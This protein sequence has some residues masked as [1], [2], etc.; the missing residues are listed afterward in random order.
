MSPLSDVQRTVLGT[1]KY[2][3]QTDPQ[4][5]KD[6]FFLVGEE[7]TEKNPKAS[8]LVREVFVP[9]ALSTQD[10]TYEG[11]FLY[12]GLQTLKYRYR[13][14]NSTSDE[15]TQ[16]G[17]EMPYRNMQ[18]LLYASGSPLIIT[19]PNFHGVDDRIF[20][21]NYTRYGADGGGVKLYRRLDGYSGESK[22]LSSPE[23]INTETNEPFVEN[24]ILKVD[25]A[26]IT[27]SGVRG[28]VAVQ[29]NT[30]TF[31]CNP[32]IDPVCRLKLAPVG[33]G[34]EMCYP[35]TLMGMSFQFPCSAMNVFTPMV[36]GERVLPVLWTS[37]LVEVPE[38]RLKLFV[39]SVWVL[40]A[41]CIGIIVFGILFV[42]V[43]GVWIYYTCSQYGAKEKTASTYG[44]DKKSL[45]AATAQNET[46]DN[47]AMEEENL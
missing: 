28:Q 12:F 2:I 35:T 32:S 42:I 11:N 10:M 14:K 3:G 9:L 23:E 6:S 7:L 1:Q 18:N 13:A 24:F 45:W 26:A 17:G 41:L 36:R 20:N 31:N 39:Y 15:R 30:F 38:E 47:A 21:Q 16:R 46:P 4:P 25:N 19:L 8:N 40:Y 5:M 44:V 29:V 27:G 33:A 34:P 22:I 43:F 37:A